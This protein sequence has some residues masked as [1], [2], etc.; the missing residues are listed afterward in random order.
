MVCSCETTPHK[1]TGAKNTKYAHGGPEVTTRSR[2]HE[3]RESI[4]R[5]Q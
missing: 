5:R 1:G 3:G 2:I 4:H